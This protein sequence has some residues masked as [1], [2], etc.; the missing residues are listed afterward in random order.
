MSDKAL[1][2]EIA[3]IK[4]ELVETKRTMLLMAYDYWSLDHTAF[5]KIILLEKELKALKGDDE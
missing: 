2:K 3:Q 5:E 4:D 1:L